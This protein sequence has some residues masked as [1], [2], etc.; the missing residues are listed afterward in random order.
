[1]KLASSEPGE[2]LPLASKTVMIVEKI[3][4]KVRAFARLVIGNR[5]DADE[6]VEDALILYLSTDPD[7]GQAEES[8]AFLIQA[9]RRLMRTSGAPQRRGTDLEAALTPL[10]AMPIETREIAAL[11]LGAGLTVDDVARLL[12]ITPDETVAGLNMARAAIG[13]QVFNEAAPA[14]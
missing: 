14:G 12:E 4:R 3:L 11:H 8:C 1:M 2:P 5:A 9:V 6:V 10:L 13:P 7:P